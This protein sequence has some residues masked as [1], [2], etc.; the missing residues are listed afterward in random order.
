MTLPPPFD[1]QSNQI[2]HSPMSF[3][4]FVYSILMGK[5]MIGVGTIAQNPSSPPIIFYP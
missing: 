1:H 2:S 4:F 3:L 5:D